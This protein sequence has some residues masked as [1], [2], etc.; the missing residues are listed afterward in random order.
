[1]ASSTS[2]AGR[3]YRAVAPFGAGFGV[4]TSSH[5]G[6]G[7][8]EFACRKPIRLV[9]GAPNAATATEAGT[10]ENAASREN[11]ARRCAHLPHPW[12]PMSGRRRRPAGLTSVRRSNGPYSFPVGRFHKGV[13]TK[14]QGRNQCDQAY[15]SVFVDQLARRELFPTHVAPALATMRPNSPHDPA[16]KLVEELADVGL[17]VVLAPTSDDRVDLVDQLLRT[18]RSLAPGTLADLVFEVPDGFFTWNR[19]AR[20]PAYPALDLRGLQ[21]ERPLALFDPC[22]SAL[23]IHPLG[24]DCVRRM[25]SESIL[26]VVCVCINRIGTV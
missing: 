3:E 15:K 11:R 26:H 12:L 25:A 4:A 10:P 1:M 16:V 24:V 18:D 6:T 7:G 20:S 9:T 2:V 22:L 5:L 17:A 8:R 23:R 19:I 21:P 14:I 13:S